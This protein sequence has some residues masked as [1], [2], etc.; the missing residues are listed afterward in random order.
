MSSSGIRVLCL[1][2]HALYLTIV[3]VLFSLALRLNELILKV[4]ASSYSY[5]LNHPYNSLDKS[6][7]G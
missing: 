1:V 6:Q 2:L 7:S 4:K 5:K 3:G